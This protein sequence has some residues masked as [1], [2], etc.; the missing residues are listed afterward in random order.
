MDA[1]A[2]DH[3]NLRYP[4]GELEAAL[5]FY[6]EKLGF[7]PELVAYDGDGEPYVDHPSHFSVRLSEDSLIH[8]TPEAEPEI[9]NR[10]RDERRTSFDHVG[11]LLDEP[12]EA[13]KRRLDEAGVEV[14]REF[15]P[16]GATGVAPA[17]FVVDPFGY[18][19]ELKEDPDR[20]RE[21]NDAIRE[22]YRE[23]EDVA[24]IAADFGV[25]ERVVERIVDYRTAAADR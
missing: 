5:E 2:I 8:M 9:V 21:R 25:D 14:R 6:C 15:E 4:E 10:Y 19:L 7:E 17:V 22:R 23:G 20:R 18:L 16:G 24:A 3:V 11:I 12:I 13:I 1:T